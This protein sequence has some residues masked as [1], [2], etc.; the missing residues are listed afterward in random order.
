[1]SEASTALALPK[2][3]GAIAINAEWIAQRDALVSAASGIIVEND[4]QYGVACDLLNKITKCSSGMEKLRKELTEPYLSAQSK[5]KQ[6]AD[7]A[8]VPLEKAKDALQRKLSPYA[9]A[10]RKREHEERLAAE[11]AAAEE[12]ARIAAENAEAKEIL[13]ESAPAQEV[14]HVVAPVERR[15]VSG[16]AKVVTRIEWSVVDIERVPRAF[17]MVDPRLVNQFRD[18]HAELI[19]KQIE[20]NGGCDAVPGIAFKLETKVQSSGR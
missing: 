7:D 9:K 12:S 11:R 2:M 17:L 3:G 20:D 13:G 8:R 19:T 1:M 18:A 5:I 4:M 6:L 14:V 10:Q 16:A 15:A